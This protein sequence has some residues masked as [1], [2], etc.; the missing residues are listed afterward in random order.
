MNN[1]IEDEV[2]KQFV[3]NACSQKPHLLPDIIK[4]ATAGVQKFAEEQSDKSSKLEFIMSQILTECPQKNFGPFSR[5]EILEKMPCLHG[6]KWM[7]EELAKLSV[8]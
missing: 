3:F 4:Y 7:N 6:T 1:L 2:I 8:D 5:K